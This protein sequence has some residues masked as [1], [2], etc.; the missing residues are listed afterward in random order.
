MTD[1]LF[2]ALVEGTGAV[3]DRIRAERGELRSRLRSHGALLFRGFEVGDAEGLEA[4]V[5]T[6]SGSR[7]PTPSSPRRGR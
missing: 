5:R 2:P 4:A 1:T 7:W 3:T 6:L